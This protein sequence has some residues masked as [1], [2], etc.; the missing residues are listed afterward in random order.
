MAELAKEVP[1]ALENAKMVT[2][3]RDHVYTQTTQPRLCI[4]GLVVVDVTVPGVGLIPEALTQSEFSEAAS[5]RPE[6]L[7]RVRTRLMAHA[8]VLRWRLEHIQ[9]ALREL[10]Q[11]EQSHG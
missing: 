11:R 10:D 2:T 1:D 9:D 8:H 3:A 5:S 6:A 4:S 7:G